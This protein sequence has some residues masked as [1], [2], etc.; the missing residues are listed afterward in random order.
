MTR[1]S[2]STV[3]YLPRRVQNGTQ[4]T[5]NVLAVVGAA[6]ENT[7]PFM[8]EGFISLHNMV[9]GDAFLV[10]EEIRDQDDAT[11]R[12]LGRTTFYAVQTSP[13]VWFENKHC[14]GWRIRIQRVSGADRDVTYQ[15]FRRW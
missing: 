12:E 9:A 15:I 4:A 5:T 3:S 2:A 11:Y 1:T 7:V 14:M 10:L 6:I 8:V 13:M